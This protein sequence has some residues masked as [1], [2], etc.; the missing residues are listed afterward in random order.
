MAEIS[1]TI[2]RDPLDVAATI[3][4]A[5]TP[6][7][8]GI[9]V[10]VGTVRETPATADRDAR[11]THLEYEAHPV[12]AEQRLRELAR[13]AA[14]KWGLER[15][16]AV[17]R[18]GHCDLG[19]PTVVIACSAAHRAEALDACRWLIDEIKSEVPIWKKE[20]YSD[21]STWI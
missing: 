10:F 7:T 21:G 20:H 3:G 6:R 18:T 1:T 5:A 15:V 9:G 17:H 12:L 13:D 14:G 8:G 16:V 4:A 19:E 2:S 11:V